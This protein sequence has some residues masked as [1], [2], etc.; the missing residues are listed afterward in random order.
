[1]NIPLEMFILGAFVIGLFS[2]AAFRTAGGVGIVSALGAFALSFL[3]AKIII[4]GTL[5]QN[6]GGIDEAG[7][8]VQGVTV[9]Q[10]PALSYVFLFVAVVMVIQFINQ[11]ISEIRFQVSPDIEVFE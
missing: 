7:N 2:I 9:I 5:V 1:M 11:V 8:I 10:V 4:N 6:I 3:C